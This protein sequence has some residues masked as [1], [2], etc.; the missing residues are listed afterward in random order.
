MVRYSGKQY[1]NETTGAYVTV[2]YAKAN[3]AQSQTAST[4]VGAVAN[5]KIRVLQVAF[6]CGGT[7]T[8]ATILSASTAIS[9]LFA[10]GA[11]GGAVLPFTMPGWF[12]TTAGEALTLTTGAGSTTGIMVGYVEI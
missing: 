6:M 2:K 1:W 8:D 7:A 10:N 3:I 12:E 4:V 11:N 9:P 5:K